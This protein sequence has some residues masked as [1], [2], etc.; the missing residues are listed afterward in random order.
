MWR[1]ESYGQITEKLTWG[2]GDVQISI[3]VSGIEFERE[4]D[5][6]EG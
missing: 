4:R 5:V 3:P 2:Q 1:W 6:P